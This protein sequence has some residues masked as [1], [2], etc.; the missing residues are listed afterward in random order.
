MEKYVYING[1]TLY[2]KATGNSGGL[3]V[4]DCVVGVLGGELLLTLLG[5]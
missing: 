1:S 4:G 3:L 5:A 2:I